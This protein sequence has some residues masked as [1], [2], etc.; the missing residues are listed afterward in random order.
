MTQSVYD[1]FDINRYDHVSK[2][3][4]ENVFWANEFVFMVRDA[5]KQFEPNDSVHLIVPA[6]RAAFLA[7]MLEANT[8]IFVNSLT[9][10][11]QEPHNATQEP[12]V[13]KSSDGAS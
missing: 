9:P 10:T 5:V 7:D 4:L 2:V 3:Q 6:D 1:L 13:R 8:Q 12:N 11:E